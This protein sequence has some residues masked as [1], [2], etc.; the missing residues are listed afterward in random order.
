MGHKASFSRTLSR[1]LFERTKDISGPYDHITHVS[2]PPE[3]GRSTGNHWLAFE[4]LM[5]MARTLEISQRDEEEVQK[6]RQLAAEEC[7][8]GY[9][10]LSENLMF[11][12]L[13]YQYV[14]LFGSLS[15]AWD[16]SHDRQ[17][18]CSLLLQRIQEALQ[19]KRHLLLVE[20]LHVPASLEVLVYIMSRRR[21]SPYQNRWLISTTSEEVYVASRWDMGADAYG[22]E[23][24]LSSE[25]YHHPN[26]DGLCDDKDWAALIREALRDV[27]NS[28][29]SALK[30]QGRDEEFWLHI[31]MNCFYYAI[32]YHPLQL[33]AAGRKKPSNDSFVSSDELVRCWVAEDLVFSKTSPTDTP[34]ARGEKPNSNYYRSA[35]EAGKVIFHALQEYS[36]LPIYSVSRQISNPSLSTDAVTGLSKIAGG[37]PWLKHDELFDLQKSGQLRWVSFMEDD[38]RHV[39]WNWSFRYGPKNIPGEMNMTTLILRGCPNISG[40]QVVLIHYLRVLDLS[41]TPINSLP[42]WICRLSNLALLSLRGCSELHTLSPQAPASVKESSPLSDLGKLEVLDMNGVPLLELTQQDGNNKSNLHY[43]DLSG[44]RLTTLPSKFFCEMSC[45]EELILGNCSHLETLPPSLA[46]LSNLLILHVEGTQISYFPEGA[47]EAMQRLHTLKLIRNMLLV[48]LP[49]SLSKAKGLKELHIYNCVSL[50]IQF[51]WELLSCLEDLYIQGWEGLED[52]QILEHPN[53]KTFSLSGKRI[54]CLSLRGCSRLKTVGFSDDLRA[55][56]DVDLSGTAIEEV[57][58]ILPNLPQLRMLLLLNVPCYKRFPWH[59]LVRFPE[60]FYLDH[61]NDDYNQALMMFCQ[62][63]TCADGN[64]YREK[65][66]NTAEININDPSIFHSFNSDVAKLIKDGQFLQCFN[67]QV[68]PKSVRCMEP[69]NKGEICPKIQ[70]QSAYLDVHFSEADSIVPMMKLQPKQRH[71][72]ISAY[73]QYSHGLRHL[74]SVAKSIYIM[75]DSFIRCFTELNFIMMCLEECQLIH[76]REM[77][78]VLKMHS[79]GAGERINYGNR[80]TI[81]PEVFPSLKI[82]QVSNLNNLI[83]LV[84]P[85]DLTSSKLLTLK[86]LNH[87]HLEHC[88]RLEKLFPCSLSLPALETLV[89]LFCS[90]LK[91]IFYKQPYYE[92]APSPL[93]NIKRIYFQELP[94]LQH[95]HDDVTFQFETPN[96]EKLLVRG[97]HSFHRL[98]LLKQKYPKSKVV[99][100]GKRDWWGMLQWSLRGQSDYYMH[101][102]PP[103]FISCK[104]HIIRSYLR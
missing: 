54:R 4:V 27:A 38:G 3:A 64:Q 93:P 84:E 79:K 78:V 14:E 58:H 71:L 11:R 97:C 70:K 62:Q 9:G 34:A 63:K 45:L 19:G 83:S 72:E 46:R 52:I 41:Y 55:L 47:F 10:T 36:L 73:T 56:E 96:W 29:H 18:S 81:T 57:P 89:I 100:S 43:L 102:P 75:D 82:L 95:L 99:V 50:S 31:A 7:Y 60:V 25:H 88:P 37:V 20:N 22:D 65:T 33:G 92:V 86:L 6:L 35:Y 42:S 51:L 67:V 94:Q 32:L 8:F 17:R 26:F 23:W 2:L 68:K 74:V 30:Q 15:M 101:V 39:S 77:E 13:G 87:I 90:N 59:Q 66:F 40:F 21:P 80:S 104:K 5:E 91:T 53:L 1:L 69:K 16:P 24:R 49:T 98:P 44:S 48:S 85:S 76:C 28:I 12:A 61:C 103:E